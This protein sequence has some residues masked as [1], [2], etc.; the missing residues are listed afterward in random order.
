MFIFGIL[1]E[2]RLLLG[3]Y[4][5]QKLNLIIFNN[6]TERPRLNILF[7]V[8]CF[9][10]CRKEAINS[11]LCLKRKFSSLSTLTKKQ[12][13]LRTANCHQ[14]LKIKSL[15]ANQYQNDMV[16]WVLLSPRIEFL[17][18]RKLRVRVISLKVKNLFNQIVT[19]MRIT[20]RTKTDSHLTTKSH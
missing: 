15:F 17:R 18:M 8:I 1:R 11:S 12:P 14:T 3:K 16:L 4:W 9:V 20:G 10:K 5:V 7:T 6:E 13:W 2:S 19:R